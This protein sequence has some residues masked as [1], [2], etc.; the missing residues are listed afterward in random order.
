MSI[1]KKSRSSTEGL[2]LALLSDHEGHERHL[3][4]ATR[5][6]TLT[7]KQAAR[8]TRSWQNEEVVV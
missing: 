6:M 2:S 7:A 5:A 4:R 1:G 8:K 3:E